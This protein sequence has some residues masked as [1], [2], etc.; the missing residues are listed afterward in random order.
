MK[1]GLSLVEVVIGLTVIGIAFYL[2]IAVFVAIVPRTVVIETFNKKNY[3]A[4]E[5][6]EEYLTRDF[7]GII[8]VGAAAFTGDFSNYNYQI[9]VTYVATND[10]NAAVALSPYKNVKVRVWGGPVDTAGTVE[11][12]SVVATYEVQ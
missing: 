5:K 9:V 8:S 7:T 6:M 1:K 3:L 11:I 12:T 4:Q 10:L 2:L